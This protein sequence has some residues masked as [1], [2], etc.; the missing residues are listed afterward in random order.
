MSR[1]HIRTNRTRKSEVGSLKKIG[2]SEVPEVGSTK[3]PT[4]VCKYVNTFIQCVPY[5][6]THPENAG[7]QF[8][9]T[10]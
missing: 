3:S 10:S 1:S 4:C 2:L 8:P 6:Q 9:I 7:T 5:V